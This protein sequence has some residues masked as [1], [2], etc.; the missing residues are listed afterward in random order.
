MGGGYYDGDV[1]ERSRSTAV[2]DFS[3]RLQKRLQ[4]GVIHPDVDPKGKIRECCDS[5][6]H[7]ETTPIVP[8]FDATFTRKDDSAVAHAKMPM[9][10]GQ[11]YM[12]GYVS[13]PQLCLMAIGDAH[14][15]DRIVFQASQFEADNRIDDNLEIMP[16]EGGGGGTG[17]ESY[18]IAAFYLARRTKLDCWKRGKKGKAF[19]FADELFYPFVSR[20]QVKKYLGVN[21]PNDIPTAEI[22]QEL[23]EKYDV[24]VIFP[25]QTWDQRKVGIDK[26]IEERVTRA[27]GMIHGVDVRFSLIWNNRNDLDL[28][29][30]APSGQEVWYGCKQSM[31]GGE[32]DVDQNVRGENP[33]PVE[34]TRW[35]RNKAPAGNYEVWVENYGFH[36]RNRRGTD[37]KVEI[38]INGQVTYFEGR[39]ADEAT[40]S[41]SRVKVGTFN[42][43]PTE[44]QADKAETDRY[45]AYDEAKILAGWASVIPS[46]RIFMIDDPKAAMDLML[47][48]LALDGGSRDLDGYVKDLKTKGQ[49]HTR[50]EQVKKSLANFADVCAAARVDVSTAPKPG[51]A[52]LSRQGASRRL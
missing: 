14:F 50:I 52:T 5:P 51:R 6:E 19:F 46:E 40:G 22:F 7:P 15:P 16:L 43:D 3:T 30:R 18:E 1:A 24:F 31:C 17:E 8:I 49:T 45:A 42:Y 9:V 28:H 23:Q 48:V 32:L 37:F 39:T 20:E 21:I 44:R 33:K 10:I 35:P 13:D 47:G 36:E 4:T 25:R 29:V 27:G 41:A 2:E 38:E 26:E 34:N 12:N 11:I